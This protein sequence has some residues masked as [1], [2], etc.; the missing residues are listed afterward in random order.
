MYDLINKYTFIL[1]SAEWWLNYGESTPILRKI[2]MKVL[3]QTTTSSNC[4]RNWSTF[5]FI[6]T[7]V[8][9]RLTMQKLNKLVYIHYNIKLR[10]RQ[11]RRREFE[12][13]TD[14]FCPINL[15]YIFSEN[16]DVLAQWIEEVEEPVLDHDEQIG[17]MVQ[18]L[19]GERPQPMRAAERLREINLTHQRRRG[20]DPQEMRDEVDD[21][22][23]ISLSSSSSSSDVPHDSD[24]D[25]GGDDGGDGGEI[26]PHMME[27]VEHFPSSSNIDPTRG[28]QRIVPP[29]ESSHT[30]AGGSGYGGGEG[31]SGGDVGHQQVMYGDYY[32]LHPHQHLELPHEFYR[33]HQD[34]PQ[35]SQS[36]NDSA[37]FYEPIFVPQPHPQA[38]QPYGHYGSGGYVA[39]QFGAFYPSRNDDDD[40]D[41]IEQGRHSFWH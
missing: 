37:S 11:R 20:I 24:G 34:Y 36:T 15:D 8:R 1:F 26:P 2:V 4:E 16:D 7:K 21:D 29:I 41:G 35:S 39:Q 38:Q 28:Y 27:T 23:D 25:G 19:T 14:Y 22:E 17:D 9:N 12:D 30:G 13:Q 5:S 18:D 31:T 6:H 10:H 33:Q 32:V 3:S 40:D